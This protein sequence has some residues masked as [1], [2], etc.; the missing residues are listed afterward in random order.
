[1][2]HYTSFR[3]AESVSPQHP[4]KLCDQ[5]SDAILDAYL[6]KDPNSRVAVEACGGHGQVFVVGEVTS[7]VDDVDI[8]GIVH[9]IAGDDLTVMQNC[10]Y[11][12]NTL[13]VPYI[14]VIFCVS[15]MYA[16]ATSL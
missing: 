2:E 1:M 10:R 12:I 5:I 11:R 3:T 8:E 15:Y 13:I 4:D 7:T 6:A 16:A 9:R 14:L